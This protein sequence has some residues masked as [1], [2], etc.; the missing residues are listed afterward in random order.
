ME[1][2]TSKYDKN[3]PLSIFNYAANLIGH[4]L[5]EMVGDE[6]LNGYNLSGKGGFNQMIEKLYFEYDVNSSPEPDFREAGVELK[7]TGLKELKDKT[8]QIKERLVIDMIDYCEVVKHPFEESLF[9]KKC[10]L[11]LLLFYLYR[12]DIKQIDWEFIYVVLWKI[13]DKDLLII[14]NDYQVII[15]KILAGNAHL[16]SVGDT[17]YLGACR[18]GHKGD[19]ERKQPYSKTFISFALHESDQKPKFTLKAMT[20]ILA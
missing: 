9:Y 3:D 2:N 19:S 6:A 7:G 15:D 1:T 10:R 5:R 11:M 18:K 8:L 17:E 12:K 20:S 4:S 14:K 13:P 16:L